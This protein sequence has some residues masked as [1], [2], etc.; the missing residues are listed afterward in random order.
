[1]PSMN[2]EGK[3]RS[4]RPGDRLNYHGIEWRVIE[5]NTYK[6]RYGYETEEWLLQ[7]EA[8]KKYYLLREIDP[9]N[10]ESAVNWYLAEPIKNAKI[11]LPDSQNNIT[12]QLWHDMQHQ[13]MPYPELKMF[14]KV[15]FFESGTKGTYEE[16]KDETSRITWDYWDTTHEANLALE[17]WQ[18]GD[19][20]IYSTK[21]VNIKAFSIA[22]KNLQ[23]SWW[24]RALRVSLGTAGLLLLLVGCS[25]LIFG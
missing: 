11:Y 2:Y 22:H 17:A 23:N 18:N 20:H 12:N 1:M 5:Y 25:M 16:G 8:R 6:D 4:L 15:Y 10:P 7:W 3:L 13:E 19:L 14:G 21:L 9:Q 24:L